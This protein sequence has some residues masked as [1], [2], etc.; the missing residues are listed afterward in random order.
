M[1]PS[2]DNIFKI[3]N[4]LSKFNGMDIVTGERCAEDNFKLFFII[5]L[6]IMICAKSIMQTRNSDD[7]TTIF[8]NVII[9]NIFSSGLFRVVS[10]V[11]SIRYQMVEI[12][13]LK[14]IYKKCNVK[15][16]DDVSEKILWETN[17]WTITFI[18]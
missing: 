13:W 7:V 1:P 14:S 2:F 3:L 18:R 10:L 4:K 16:V 12:N 5:S 15:V 17:Q 6:K 9:F 8:K 11:L